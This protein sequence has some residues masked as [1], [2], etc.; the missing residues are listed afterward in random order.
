MDCTVCFLFIRQLWKVSFGLSPLLRL[1]H[2]VD[3]LHPR[4]SLSQ[5]R[6]NSRG[7]ERTPSHLKPPTVPRSNYSARQLHSAR[8]TQHLMMTH[9][10][11]LVEETPEQTGAFLA[12]QHYPARGAAAERPPSSPKNCNRLRFEPTVVVGLSRPDLSECG[13]PPLPRG[14]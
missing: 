3:A 12:L 13:F 1:F 5:R 6:K 14:C 10:L 7:S 9:N 8:R 11:L 2:L 4:I